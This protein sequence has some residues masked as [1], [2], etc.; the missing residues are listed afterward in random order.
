MLAI[1]IEVV[2]WQKTSIIQQPGYSQGYISLKNAQLLKFLKEKK[3]KKKYHLSLQFGTERN[4][5]TFSKQASVISIQWFAYTKQII[6][7]ML[8]RVFILY[9]I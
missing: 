3:K 1:D 9:A 4:S 5:A 8:Y 6:V 2:S 7:L